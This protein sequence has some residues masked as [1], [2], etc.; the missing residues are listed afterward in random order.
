MWFK[1]C[2][3]KTATVRHS[4]IRDWTIAEKCFLKRRH[5]KHTQYVPTAS[6]CKMNPYAWHKVQPSHPFQT[7][8]SIS[9]TC[10]FPGDNSPTIHMYFSTSDGKTPALGKT[11]NA[12]TS[13]KTQSKQYVQV[14]RMAI[15]PQDAQFLQIDVTNLCL[16]STKHIVTRI[17]YEHQQSC[18]ASGNITA[19]IAHNCRAQSGRNMPN[20]GDIVL[21]SLENSGDLQHQDR[22]QHLHNPRDVAGTREHTLE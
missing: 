20:N 3:P 5:K 11:A 14:H 12:S 18:T 1:K 13:V 8:A 19:I 2:S 4:K 10:W 9:N 22:T 21:D 17:H 6:L 7:A 16:K 15:R